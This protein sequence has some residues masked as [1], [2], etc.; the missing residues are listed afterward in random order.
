M[1]VH[2]FYANTYVWH[3]RLKMAASTS[4]AVIAEAV[5]EVKIIADIWPDYY[6]LTSV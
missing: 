3:V 1:C 4:N 5:L 2:I 6:I